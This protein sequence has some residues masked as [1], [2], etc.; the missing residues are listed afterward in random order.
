MGVRDHGGWPRAHSWRMRTSVVRNCQYQV[1]SCFRPCPA[2]RR[3]HPALVRSGWEVSLVPESILKYKLAH[4]LGSVKVICEGRRR[5]R[6]VGRSLKGTGLELRTC[7]RGI[8]LKWSVGGYF[9]ALEGCDA[10]LETRHGNIFAGLLERFED[11]LLSLS[12][13][14]VVGLRL[15]RMSSATM[16]FLRP[17]RRTNPRDPGQ[18]PWPKSI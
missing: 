14:C 4:T 1:T 11:S 16:G 3:I 12:A 8:F 9:L 5:T 17:V 7:I 13:V 18:D 10:L 15:L 2:Q 6:L